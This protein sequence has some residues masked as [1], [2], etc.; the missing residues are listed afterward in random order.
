MALLGIGQN[1]TVNQPFQWGEGGLRLTPEDIAMRRQLAEQQQWM[2]SDFSP[3]GSV[4]EGLG[5]VVQG[6]TGGLNERRA[7][8]A[9]E[10]NRAESQ[11]IAELLM[12]KDGQAPSSASIIA[13]ALNPY[14]DDNTRQFALMQQQQ[15]NARSEASSP[16]GKIAAD[17]GFVPGTPEFNNRV[18]ELNEAEYRRL[19]PIEQG[20]AAI[21]YNPLTGQAEY[22]VAPA[23]LAAQ[24]NSQT[25]P[26]IPQGAID[27]LRNGEG[28][29][30]QFDE[31]FGAG[32]AARVLGM[33]GAA[34]Q[35]NASGYPTSMT[36]QQYQ[37][38]EQ[39]LGVNETAD[40]ARRNGIMVGQ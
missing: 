12:P 25:A 24:L 18:R 14:I 3:V 2:G 1:Q 31:A 6:Y 7:N 21:T 38:V 5:R 11:S 35:L 40:W 26:E 4:W 29:A 22:A 27:A 15:M 10:A 8:R 32:S 30:A 28:S 36:P 34:P 9:E 23:N 13:A 33:S 17:E 19:T 37:A 16:L 20:G 39:A